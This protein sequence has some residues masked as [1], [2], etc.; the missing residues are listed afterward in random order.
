MGRRQ[1]CLSM[2]DLLANQIVK[3]QSARVCLNVISVKEIVH[4]LTSIHLKLGKT[5]LPK[6]CKG[7]QGPRR[8]RLVVAVQDVHP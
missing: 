2:L 4:G 8:K 5:T 1:Q 7:L 3:F 6:E